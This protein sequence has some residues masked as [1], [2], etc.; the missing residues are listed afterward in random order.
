MA[1]A[2]SPVS[3]LF[4]L[5]ITSSSGRSPPIGVKKGN[6]CHSFRRGPSFFFAP[7][8][9]SLCGSPATLQ[10]PKCLKLH[11]IIPRGYDQETGKKVQDYL[12]TA[13]CLYDARCKTRLED[14]YKTHAWERDLG[15]VRTL[16]P[17]TYAQL[18]GVG[19][20]GTHSVV[21][22]K[23][24][25][26]WLEGAEMTEDDCPST[27]TEMAVD[28][29][30]HTGH[31]LVDADATVKARANKL[32][33]VLKSVNDRCTRLHLPKAIPAKHVRRVHSLRSVGGPAAIGI[34][35]RLRFKAT[36][37]K[38]VLE[39]QLSKGNPRPSKWG[40]TI[41]AYEQRGQPSIGTRDM[42]QR[43]SIHR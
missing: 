2:T 36:K 37:T 1:S 3:Y 27:Y 8:H 29:E 19:K 17:P 41:P 39:Q 35:K 21:L 16:R 22:V 28:F 15:A 43:G 10:L 12:Y 23:K 26:E 14:L 30:T 40:D 18:T 38:T 24:V 5:N 32:W 20:V 9:L 31:F 13:V 34:R 25:L 42:L 4:T 33:R 11:G 6:P 7:E